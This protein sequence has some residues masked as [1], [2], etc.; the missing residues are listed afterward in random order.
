MGLT[1]KKEVIAIS[2]WLLLSGLAALGRNLPAI[3]VVPGDE[4]RFRISVEVSQVP[5]SDT[6]PGLLRFSVSAPATHDVHRGRLVLVGQ[7]GTN[8]SFSVTVAT[9]MEG[10]RILGQFQISRDQLTRTQCLIQYV[11]GDSIYTAFHLR[12]TEFI[13]QKEKRQNQ[14]SNRTR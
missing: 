14:P 7:S 3:E 12:L 13:K 5:D 1:M 2:G 11:D 6:F 9:S 8:I 4:E 10:D